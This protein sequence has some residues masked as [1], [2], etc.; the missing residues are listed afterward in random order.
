MKTIAIQIVAAVVASLIVMAIVNKGA[1]AC[2]R[3]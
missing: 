1:C 3:P 2:S